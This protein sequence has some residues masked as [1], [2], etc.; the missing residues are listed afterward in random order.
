MKKHMVAAT[1]L[2]T[3]VLM[4]VLC[5][6]LW[7]RSAV[8]YWN[9]A[10]PLAGESSIQK[11][12]QMFKSHCLYT[13][14][15]VRRSLN[16]AEPEP[17]KERVEFP[18]DFLR[19]RYVRTVVMNPANHRYSG[20]HTVL[21]NDLA[22][23][24]REG[25]FCDGSVIIKLQYPV[26]MDGIRNLFQADMESMFVIAKDTRRFPKE[27]GGWGFEIFDFQNK[28]RL[29]TNTEVSK[30]CYTCHSRSGREVIYSPMQGGVRALQIPPFEALP[31]DQLPAHPPS[32]TKLP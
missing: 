11:S 8:K 21:A 4:A 15:K 22:L 27:M 16:L 3:N 13:V 30:W 25:P 2:A 12:Q 18:R 32:W 14:D 23:R 19:F 1:L 10:V 31:L 28:S 5:W 7:V 24:N 6:H 26:V 29:V 20:F 9:T 17:L